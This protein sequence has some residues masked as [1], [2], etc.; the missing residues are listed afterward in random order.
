M[1]AAMMRELQ[2]HISDP[3]VVCQLEMSLG[4]RDWI[5]RDLAINDGRPSVSFPD[6]TAE[7]CLEHDVQLQAWAPLARGLY[8]GAMLATT[9]EAQQRTSALVSTMAE[10]R[11]TSPEAI[12]LGWLLRHPANIQPVIGTS[13]PDRIR[14]CADSVRQA[15]LMTRSEWYALLTS[16]RGANPP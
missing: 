6:G 12:V 14:A 3:L 11:G 1:S 16:A 7:Y 4:K 10:S 9:T 13:D 8:S 5:E 2:R 15:D